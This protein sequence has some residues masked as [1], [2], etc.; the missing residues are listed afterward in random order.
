MRMSADKEAGW[1]TAP[2]CLHVEI[3]VGNLCFA[4][5]VFPSL[6]SSVVLEDCCRCL[7]CFGKAAAGGRRRSWSDGATASAAAQ[8]QSGDSSAAGAGWGQ[9]TEAAD[10]VVVAVAAVT[11]VAVVVVVVAAAVVVEGAVSAV[12]ST[13]LG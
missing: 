11:A 2:V 12:S 4:R 13:E 3:E 9:G 8:E 6:G 5:L 7:G 1:L 10:V